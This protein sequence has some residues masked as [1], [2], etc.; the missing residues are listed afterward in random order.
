MRIP[1]SKAITLLTVALMAAVLPVT[2]RGDNFVDPY[3][4]YDESAALDME[5]EENLAT[6]PVQPAEKEAVKRYMRALAQKLGQKYKVEL[7]RGGEV[8]VVTIPT[9]ALFLPNDT[10]LSPDAAAQLRPLLPL[11]HT[12]DMFK[13]V[14]AVHTDDTGSESYNDDLSSARSQSIYAW[15]MEDGH[16][17]Q[18]IFIINYEMGDSRPLAPNDTRARRAAN[19]RLEIF[20]VPGPRLITLA[21]EGKIR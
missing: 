5:L 15:L 8:V 3:A 1:F 6:P 4:N 9:D 21:H 18:D 20:L 14:Y 12:A 16:V 19:R 2:A 10:L 7:M 13:L 11:F 17:N